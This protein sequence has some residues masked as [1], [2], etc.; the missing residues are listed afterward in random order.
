MISSIV[1]VLVFN[2]L[3]TD[4]KFSL[5]AYDA[6]Y[7][8]TFAVMFLA[9][10]ITGSLVMRLKDHAKQSARVAFRTRILFDT[11]RL[12]QQA[13]EREDIISVTVRQLAKLL[14]RDMVVYMEENGQLGEPRV[15]RGR[16]MRSRKSIFQEK[17]VRWLCGRFKTT[18]MPEPQ[19]RPFRMLNAS[20]WQSV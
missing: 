16:K 14:E 9:A 7:P 4:P 10:F 8:I 13:K 15:F 2:F 6:G 3:F 17:N 20:I 1:S 18:N 11:N 19:Q 5:Q 12:L